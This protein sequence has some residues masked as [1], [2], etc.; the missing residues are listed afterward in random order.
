MLEGRG[1]S[2]YLLLIEAVTGNKQR[3]RPE[4]RSLL[5]KHGLVNVEVACRGGL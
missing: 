5:A 2:G 4:I 1:A 3:T